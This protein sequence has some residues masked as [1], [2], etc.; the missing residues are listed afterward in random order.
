MRVALVTTSFPLHRDSTSGIFI[1][2][3]VA[4]LTPTVAVTVVTPCDARSDRSDSR[5]SIEC[6]RYGPR[7]WQV[8]AHNA[9]GVPQQ[10]RRRPGLYALLPIFLASLFIACIRAARR[11]DLVHGNWSVNGAVAGL[12]AR[13]SNRASVVTLRGSDVVRAQQSRIYRW[14][15]RACVRLNSKIITVS[16]ELMQRTIALAPRARGKICAIPNGVAEEFMN[17]LRTPPATILRVVAVGNLIR[18]KGIDTL[19]TALHDCAKVHLRVVGTGPDAM[20]LRALAGRL[21]V[22]VEFLG[23][24]PHAKMPALLADSDV[25]VLS[26]YHE[27]RSNALLEAMASG[28]AIIASAIPGIDEVVTHETTGLLFPPGDASALSAQLQRLTDDRALCVRL[29]TAARQ[30]IQ[31]S[32]WR[33]PLTA[34]RYLALYREA[35]AASTHA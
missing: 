7:A 5:F 20:P 10:L 21:G 2:Q 30:H 17:T 25:F 13:L 14:L 28:C 18:D 31:Q 23:A 19:I 26:S 9:G 16:D 22:D 12:A 15:L 3:L 24:Q 4:H 29:G 11:A 27:G 6:F 8:L 34:A 1:A 33:W 32:P 35:V